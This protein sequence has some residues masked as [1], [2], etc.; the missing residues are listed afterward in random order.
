MGSLSRNRL[1]GGSRQAAYDD[2][3]SSRELVEKARA[4]TKRREEEQS[5]GDTDAGADQAALSRIEAA[6]DDGV[7]RLEREAEELLSATE[8]RCARLERKLKRLQASF[9]K[10]LARRSSELTEASERQ[11]EVADRLATE[12]SRLYTRF[13]PAS[14][15]LAELQERVKALAAELTSGEPA[16]D[17]TTRTRT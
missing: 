5:S 7:R 11:A 6:V 9:E 17:S 1:A 10:E 4:A 16:A 2:F 3:R 8:Q 12:F 15:H 13:H 14:A